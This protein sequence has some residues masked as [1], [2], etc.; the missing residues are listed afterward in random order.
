MIV[1]HGGSVIGYQLFRLNA[2]R[3]LGLNLS[4]AQSSFLHNT[5]QTKHSVLLIAFF[6]LLSQLSGTTAQTW[7]N[8]QA[9]L[10]VIGQPYFSICNTGL[11][12]ASLN[13][14]TGIAID[15]NNRKL[16]VAELGNHRLLRYSLDSLQTSNSSAE[17]VLG[18][19]N[20]NAAVANYS[21]P[22][23]MNYP[24]GLFVDS[25]GGLW[26]GDYWNHRVLYW[27]E[28]H[29]ITTNGQFATKVF[30]VLFAVAN[31]LSR[32]LVKRTSTLFR[33]TEVFTNLKPTLCLVLG[34]CWLTRWIISGLWTDSIG[35]W[36]DMPTSLLGYRQ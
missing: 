2:K 24:A 8:G 26:M 17:L 19:L 1:A 25:M 27:A 34:V 11:S 29:L 14:P 3:L 23:Q 33:K 7:T 13:G 21:L 22:G 12:S 20:F 32:L 28:S 4:K 30:V 10:K 15:R 36:C 9:A 6:F 18:Q 31:Y 35:E 16:W 5:M